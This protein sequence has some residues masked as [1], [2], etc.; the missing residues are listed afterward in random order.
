MH[1]MNSNIIECDVEAIFIY[2]EHN[3]CSVAESHEGYRYNL[4]N[5]IVVV[6]VRCRFS[7]LG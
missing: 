6:L 7:W 3:K 2:D 5:E 1:G 4:H